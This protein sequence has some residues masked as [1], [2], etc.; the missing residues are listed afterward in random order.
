[1]TF[2]LDPFILILLLD[3]LLFHWWLRCKKMST[4]EYIIAQR[5]KEIKEKSPKVFNFKKKKFKKIV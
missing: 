1:M 3:L 4:Y 5:T 2:V